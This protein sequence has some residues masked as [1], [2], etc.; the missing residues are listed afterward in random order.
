MEIFQEALERFGKSPAL[1][2][3]RFGEWL[4]WTYEEYYHDCFAAAKGF[5]EVHRNKGMTAYLLILN[6]LFTFPVLDLCFSSYTC[7]LGLNLI[8]V[9]ALSASMHPSGTCLIMLQ[10]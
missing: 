8:M 4:F 1:A 5:I 9:S 6:S 3:K 10:S 2:V 7:S